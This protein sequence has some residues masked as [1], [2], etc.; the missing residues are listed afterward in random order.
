MRL[1]YYSDRG[2]Y[3]GTT[4]VKGYREHNEDTIGCFRLD[5]KD[6]SEL[7]IYV[8]VV[9]DGMGGGVRGKYASSLTVQAIKSVVG[10]I[11]LSDSDFDEDLNWLSL[12]Q[13]EVSKGIRKAH[14][15]LCAEYENKSTCATTC[16]VAIVQGS[17]YCTIQI[18][19]TRV[20]ELSSEGLDL[21]T[22]DD[23]WAFN[24]LKSGEMT[25]AEIRVHKNRH[26]ITKAVGVYRGFRLQESEVHTLKTGSGIL[27]T[28]DGFSELLTEQK[29]KLIWSKENQLESMSKMMVGE[30]QKDNISAI[31]YVP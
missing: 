16:S 19:D 25:E 2:G 29:A 11:T 9:C 4:R 20:Y 18:G 13:K 24:K 15:R 30:G 8:L 31:F 23:S 5:L 28:S 6:N 12:V 3:N 22:E 26:M 10:S 7:P 14:M 27:V 17:H 21:K 1:E